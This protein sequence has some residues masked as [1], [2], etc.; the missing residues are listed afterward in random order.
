MSSD[1]ELLELLII[2]NRIRMPV[3]MQP[4]MTP[5]RYKFMWGGRA[6]SK[7]YSCGKAL[8]KRA[9]EEKI[10]VLCAREFQNSIAESVHSELSGLIDELNYTDYE[11]TK[12]SIYNVRTKSEF[13]FAGLTGQDKKQSVK[14]FADVDVCWI[15]EAQSI[16]K[17]SLDILLPTIRKQGSEIWF[18]YNIRLSDDPVELLRRKI[19]DK[20]KVE[21]NINWYDNPYLSDV[22]LA[23]IQ[24][25][26]KLYEDN[27][28]DDYLHTWLGNPIN[29]S[30]KSIFKVK[31]IDEAI[32]REINDEGQIEIG[33]DVARFGGD[34]SVMFKRKGLKVIDYR[35]F[36]KIDT[37][38][39]T[40]QVID[41]ADRDRAIK[42]KVDD[43]GVGGGVTDQLKD[44]G[45]NVIPVNNGQ[46]A[47]DS[48]KYNNAISEMWFTL[49][50]KIN[51]ISLM[52]IQDLKSELLTREWKLDNKARRVVESK[53]DYKKRG[54]RS[55][56][57][58]DAL[59]LCF[60]QPEEEYFNVE[61][62]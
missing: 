11:V 40:R 30:D 58:A 7:T 26:K 54:F 38:E 4:V 3:K 14:G 61:V 57:F 44:G 19:E 41:F 20:D 18:T 36:E 49:K 5:K 28:N 8:L 45:Y 29:I 23:D 53:D 46:K 9:N 1:V 12:N 25:D 13:I 32:N 52:D 43:S 39:L 55:P 60:Y 2:E 17:G 21:I 24:R 10:K 33:V 6:G 50:E 62:L 22:I 51:D 27:V 37:V 56:D 16:S 42:I 15:E 31:E 35:V 59:L 48:D 34:R 47:M